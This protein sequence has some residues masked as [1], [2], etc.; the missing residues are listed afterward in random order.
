M[1]NLSRRL[2]KLELVIVDQS[3]F[4]PHSSR[5]LAYWF[6]WFDQLMNGEKPPGIAPF[7]AALAYM[8]QERPR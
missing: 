4:P 1:S 3:G 7:E 5:W 6:S 2:K 8:R